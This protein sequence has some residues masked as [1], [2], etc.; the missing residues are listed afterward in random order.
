[1]DGFEWRVRN[2][3]E[4]GD[5]IWATFIHIWSQTIPTFTE[6]VD[7]LWYHHVFCLYSVGACTDCVVCQN[8]T[9]YACVYSLYLHPISSNSQRTSYKLQTHEP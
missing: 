7:M 9:G 3:P 1:M 6:D 4:M 2:H 8:L 5:F